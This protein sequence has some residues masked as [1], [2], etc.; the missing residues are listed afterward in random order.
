MKI[1]IPLDGS[2]SS[3]STL[4]WAS[5]TLDKTA[6]EY[7]LLSVVDDPMIAEYEIQ[8]ATKILE[9]GKAL[10]EAAGCKVAKA[11]YV[12][13]SPPNRI[14]DYADEMDV[15]QVLVGSHGRTG[16]AKVFLGSVSSAVLEHCNKPVFLFRNVVRNE[17]I[18]PKLDLFSKMFV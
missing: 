16:L 10:L 14:C 3:T 9:A 4:K 6:T 17:K 7:Y 2:D 13:G 8:D 18:D 12:M 5:K 11:E 1:L 15:D